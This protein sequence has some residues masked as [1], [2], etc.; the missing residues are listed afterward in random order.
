MPGVLETS[1]G[2]F[3]SGNNVNI[4]VGVLFDYPRHGVLPVRAAV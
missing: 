3:Y 2:S 1:V 4:Q